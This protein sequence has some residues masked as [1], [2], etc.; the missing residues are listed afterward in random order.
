MTPRYKAA[1]GPEL[2]F[3]ARVSQAN[4]LVLDDAKSQCEH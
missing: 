4:R 1:V 3:V 2:E